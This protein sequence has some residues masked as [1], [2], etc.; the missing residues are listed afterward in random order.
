MRL[1][2]GTPRRMELAN[3]HVL[4]GPGEALA[5]PTIRKIHVSDL[6]D[7]LEA[8]WR[9]FWEMPSHYAFLGLIYPIVGV[10]LALWTSGNNSLPL[11]YPLASGFAL[12]GPF[13]AI[14]LYEISRRRQQGLPATWTDAFEVLR[15]PA[16]PSILAIGIGLL[17]LFYFWLAS[18]QTLYQSL[19][20]LSAPDSLGGFLT[21]IFTTDRGWKL[22]IF[23]NLLGF[24]FAVVT[25]CTTV[26]AF[27]LLLDRDTGAL[28][29]IQ[30]SFRAV[31]ANPIPMLV[32][33][34]M[35]ALLLVIGSI[36]LFIGLAIVMPVLGHATWHVYRK[37]V[38]PAP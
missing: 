21:E 12:I 26:I 27:P 6:V 34:L 3:F 35:V 19:F 11:L 30:T 7:A 8:G 29:A 37:V 24:I 33:G 14:P 17:V 15:S 36:P 28:V 22:L 32:W 13:A 4:S 18:A 38:A 31:A 9:D 25:L 1:A 23:G 2:D 5:H 20:G 10:F 16:I